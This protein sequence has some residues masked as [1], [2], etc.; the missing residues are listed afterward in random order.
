MPTEETSGETPLDYLS[1]QPLTMPFSMQY[2]DPG[3]VVNEAKT[4]KADLKKALDET[5]SKV[6]KVVMPL[7]AVPLAHVFNRSLRQGTF[8]RSLKEAQVVP[9][10]K[11]KGVPRTDPNS[12]R[13]IALTD[14]IAKLFERCVKKQLSKHVDTYG[15]LAETQYGFRT[16]RS[17]E[18][19]LSVIC[20]FIRRGADGGDAVVGIFLDVAKA[21]NSLRHNIL[22]KILSHLGVDTRTCNWF[23]SYLGGRTIRV[24]LGGSLSRKSETPVGIPQGSVLGPLC[25]ILYINVV[26]SALNNGSPRVRAVSF[27]DDTSVLFKVS[28][29][30]VE[31][32]VARINEELVRTTSAFSS[33]CLALNVSKTKLVVFKSAHSRV[34]IQEGDIKL[35]DIS[36]E[37]VPSATVLGIPL[38]GDLKWSDLADRITDKCR[39]A[40]ACLFRLRSAGVP[41]SVV[42]HA[43]RVFM[44]PHLSYRIS[45]WGGTF[46]NVRQRIQVSQND[47]MRAALGL[48]WSSSVSKARAEH[49]IL[50]VEG[51]FIYRAAT[52]VY[53][54][55]IGKFPGGEML[56]WSFNMTSARNLRADRSRDLFVPRDRTIF[57]QQG[58]KD[59]AVGVWNNLPPVVKAATSL[60][61]FRGRIKVHLF[62]S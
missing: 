3:S 17:P 12:Y 56:D 32:D 49:Q 59:A 11:G 25:F 33:L 47:A 38:Q 29:D 13:P 5:P 23:S 39:I 14:F 62:Y 58:P 57:V 27:A 10:Y 61:Q 43:Y 6:L 41:L 7:I 45:V 15:L 35:N 8:P 19:A 54:W 40:T 16:A 21:F 52:N 55:S 9:L 42:L 46:R 31:D 24:R 28:K 1:R 4:M 18:L 36:L 48:R 20:E 30:S 26:L 34:S 51:L 50:S 53:K 60:Q 22:I 2:I 44:E 37:A